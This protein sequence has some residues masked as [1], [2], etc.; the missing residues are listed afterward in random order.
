MSF[1]IRPSGGFPPQTPREFPN[2]IQFRFNGVDLGGP[3]A[4]VVNFAGG[5]LTVERGE[6]DDA[7][8]ITISF[9]ADIR[10]TEDGT[11]R[12]MEEG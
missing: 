10:V 7:N 1:A 6:G 2:F 5:L 4:T 11:W 3:D 8:K 9:D 12:A